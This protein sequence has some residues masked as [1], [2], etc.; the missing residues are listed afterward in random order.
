M[1]PQETLPVTSGTYGL[2]QNT[3][4]ATQDP[5]ER[6]VR[7]YVVARQSFSGEFGC[8]WGSC[9]S[10]SNAGKIE[11]TSSWLSALKAL[12]AIHERL[13]RVQIEHA[14][15]RDIVRR[16]QGPGYL[17]YCDP[18]YV[19]STR[20]SGSYAHEMNDQ[21]HKDLVELLLQYNGAVVLSGYPNA[22]YQPLENAGWKRLDFRSCCTACGRTKAT[23]HKRATLARTECVWMNPE[24]IRRR[25]PG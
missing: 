18:P 6:A 22:L 13:Q 9:I 5:L 4:Y 12:P 10:C 14:D 25:P 8:S 7:W 19:A 23:A 3:W 24:A 16:Y 20:K 2:C 15:F 17:C 21:D 1:F 11:T